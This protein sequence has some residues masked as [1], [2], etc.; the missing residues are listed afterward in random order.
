MQF[1]NPDPG[2]FD[3]RLVP[4]RGATSNVKLYFLGEAP[5]RTE[6]EQLKPFVGDAGKVLHQMISRS[7][8]DETQIRMFNSI[9]YRPI[10]DGGRANRTPSDEEIASFSVF[11]KLDIQKTKPEAILCLGRSAAVSLVG[12]IGPVG[13][14]RTNS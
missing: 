4:P 3:T 9:P 12:D 6:A 11:A 8:I 1:P 14:A 13:E 7:G 2:L 10:R 5:G